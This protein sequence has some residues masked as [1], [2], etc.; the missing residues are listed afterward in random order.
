ML[1]TVVVTLCEYAP[2][3]LQM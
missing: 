1:Y 2:H 3:L